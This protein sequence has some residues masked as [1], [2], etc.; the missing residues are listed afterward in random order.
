M[1]KV[2]LNQHEQKVTLN[3]LVLELGNVVNI[4]G[5]EP[6]KWCVVAYMSAR[7][8]VEIWRDYAWRNC[9]KMSVHWTSA[10]NFEACPALIL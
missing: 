1:L 10:Q 9:L 7:M 6:K 2:A 4:C 8:R 5:A 3:Q